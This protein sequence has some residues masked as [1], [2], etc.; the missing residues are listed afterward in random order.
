MWVVYPLPAEGQL[1]LVALLRP[2][3][4]HPRESGVE[5]MTGPRVMVDEVDFAF[6]RVGLLPVGWERP[7]G[8][9]VRGR[10]FAIMILVALK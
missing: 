10:R 9:A 1:V 4:L 6:V 7:Q 3:F 8:V 2:L 5:P